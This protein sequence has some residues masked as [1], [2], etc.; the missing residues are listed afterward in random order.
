MLSVI[1]TIESRLL[2]RTPSKIGFLVLYIQSDLDDFKY[3][4]LTMRRVHK[5]GL[6]LAHYQPKYWHYAGTHCMH[7]NTA[8]PFR[9]A[10]SQQ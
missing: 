5:G 3:T 8:T 9:R 4:N 7:I 2:Y 6:G 1:P 10:D